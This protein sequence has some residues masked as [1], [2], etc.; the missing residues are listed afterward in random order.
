MSM[1]SERPIQVTAAALSSPTLEIVSERLR[2]RSFEAGDLPVFVSYRRHDMGQC[3]R[4][5]DDPV[6]HR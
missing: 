3:Y 5:G 6:M 1:S 4:A 2:L